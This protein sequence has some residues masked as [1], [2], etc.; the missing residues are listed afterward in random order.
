MQE[1]S[2]NTTLNYETLVQNNDDKALEKLSNEDFISIIEAKTKINSKILN[3]L[4]NENLSKEHKSLLINMLTENASQSSLLLKIIRDS[5][6]EDLDMEKIFPN[7]ES[8]SNKFID[9]FKNMVSGFKADLS[10]SIFF[11]NNKLP[12]WREIGKISVLNIKPDFLNNTFVKNFTDFLTSNV[13]NTKVFV[14]QNNHNIYL[15][16]Q[17][18]KIKKLYNQYKD[19]FS[20]LS[21]SPENFLEPTKQH[22]YNEKQLIADINKHLVDK[23]SM[24]FNSSKNHYEFNLLS[25]LNDSLKFE[26]LSTIIAPEVSN[27]LSKNYQ[28][29]ESLEKERSNNK[30]ISMVNDFSLKYN[31]NPILVI[32]SIKE[33]STILNGYEG[34]D[35]LQNNKEN[36]LTANSDYELLLKK[37]I[38]YINELLISKNS[39]LESLSEIKIDKKLKDDFIENLN[40][41][42]LNTKENSVSLK[43]FEDTISKIVEDENIVSINKKAVK[44]SSK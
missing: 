13:E 28:V 38:V 20:L 42:K 39:I 17:K 1:D 25:S 11:K 5:A 34:F 26:M 14:K 44:L 41:Q 32:H 10:P 19:V 31:L 21:I 33:G 29:R 3:V 24:S 12:D 2:M 18:Y 22:E 37:N 40:S 27:Q 6:V 15:I 16:G 7:K 35:K 36:I 8:N 30:Y 4:N 9:K 43:E 23:L